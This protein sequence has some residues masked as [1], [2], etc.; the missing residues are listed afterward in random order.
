MRDQNDFQALLP[1]LHYYSI[2]P[3]FT[4]S[5][6]NVT[7]IYA[8]NGDYA[9]KKMPLST[10]PHFIAKI[11]QLYEKG[12]QRIVPIFPTRDGFIGVVD[13]KYFYY[14]MPWVAS[15][16]APDYS[17]AYEN[18]FGEV[19]NLHR[20]SQEKIPIDTEER[21]IHYHQ[22]ITNWE[23]DG[24]FLLQFIED[25]EMKWY[26]SPFELL[27]CLYFDEIERAFTFAMDHFRRW[28]E[29]TKEETSVRSSIIHGKLG[30]EHF[31]FNEQEGGYFISFEKARRTMPIHDLLIFISR[32]SRGLPRR[33]SKVMEGLLTY[34]ERAPFDEGEMS[35]FLSYLSYPGHLLHVVKKYYFQQ[36]EKNERQFVQQLQQEYW[37]F[38]NI[39]FA[40]MKIVD[41]LEQQQSVENNP[42]SN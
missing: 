3:F 6:G 4:E 32:L 24:R 19:A 21:N 40:V 33:N 22:T 38:K 34:W 26:M 7:K 31:L 15:Y 14:L 29:V 9:L 27:V 41:Y 28:F 17:R 12:F 35:L 18:F 39:E 5:I 11:Q 16:D 23:N 8:G 20:L 1:I 10:G 13:E 25:S 36:G 2:Q 37:Y 42:L 30:Q